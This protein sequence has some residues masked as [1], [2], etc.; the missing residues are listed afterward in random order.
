MGVQIALALVLLTGAGLFARSLRNALAL[1][2][3]FDMDRL[4]LVGF[5][6]GQQRYDS[7]RARAFYHD[8]VDRAAASPGI[9]Y[10]ALAA[11]VPVRA[12]GA[13]S[14]AWTQG[15]DAPQNMGEQSYNFVGPGYFETLGIPIVRGRAFTSADED[16]AP[17]AV[18]V[19]EAFAEKA[20]PG[21]DAL[22]QRFWYGNPQDSPAIVVIGVAR[23]SKYRSLRENGLP[24]FY[25]PMWQHFAEAGLST[26]RLVFRS[27]AGTD[28][29]LVTI[30]GVVRSLDPALPLFQA[31]SAAAQLGVLLAAQQMGTTILGAL[32]AIGLVLALSGLYGVVSYA[33]ARRTHEIGVRIALGART[34]DVLRLMLG[35]GMRPVMWGTL[36]GVALVYVLG[37]TA[38]SF[39]YGVAPRDPFT[40]F[41]ASAILL[42]VCVAAMLTPA[43]RATRIEPTR[44]LR[45][46]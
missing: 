15:P 42:A 43:V 9:Q 4:A 27:R 8:L 21:Q 12:A 35:Q 20:W 46:E 37:K 23:N 10:A 34:R 41:A 22:G 44:A 7:A 25:L 45:E 26:M 39:M 30:R 18:I 29:S 28:Q 14:S 6:L 33:V 16:R 1:D 13:R 31:E 36:S 38:S 24:Y 17:L 40:L 11:R 2:L 19:N 5:N 3:G 32:S